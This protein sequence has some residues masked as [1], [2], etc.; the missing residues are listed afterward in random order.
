[1]RTKPKTYTAECPTCSKHSRGRFHE[2]DARTFE[3][4]GRDALCVRCLD[5]AHVK[6]MRTTG[7]RLG[8]SCHKGC[9][10]GFGK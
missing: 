3:H 7:K 10:C 2:I 9:P 8:L 5:D 4:F 1:M 6:F